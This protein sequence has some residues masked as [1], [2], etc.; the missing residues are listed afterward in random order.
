MARTSRKN[1]GSVTIEDVARVAGVSAMTVS[2]VINLKRNVRDTTRDAVLEAMTQLNYSPNAAARSLAAGEATHI[3]ILYANPSSAYLSQFLLGALEG[4]RKTGVQLLLES[5]ASDTEAEQEATARRLLESNIDGFVLSSPL[6]ESGP[7]FTE[8]SEAHVPTVTVAMGLPEDGSLNVRI[9]DRAAAREITEYLIGLGHRRFGFIRGHPNISASA[10]RF[11]GFREALA[12]AGLNPDDAAVEQGYFTYRSGLDAAERLIQASPRPTAIFASN[13]D[14][15]AATVNVAHRAGLDVPADLS[16][17]GF[18]DTAPATT[19]WPELTTIRQPI[20]EMAE[21]A[22]EML[23][24]ELRDSRPRGERAPERVLG[25]ELVVRD[26]TG[27]VPR[28]VSPVH[29]SNHRLI[30]K[31]ASSR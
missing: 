3:G 27:P 29:T 4:A 11:E 1:R 6:S 5:C 2:R 28:S 13:D 19:V 21:A 12:E 25:H 23:I 31:P 15:A 10:E 16:V 9:D 22:I 26:S 20:A 8:L 24:S 30:D 17:V 14:M 18:D 7:V